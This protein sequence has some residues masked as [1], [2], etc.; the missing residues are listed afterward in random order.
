[1]QR[2]ELAGSLLSLLFEDCFKTLNG[3]LRAMADRELV[4]QVRRIDPAPKKY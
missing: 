2:L 1:V 3:K 4:K